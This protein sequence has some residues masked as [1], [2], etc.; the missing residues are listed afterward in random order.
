MVNEVPQT[1]ELSQT[2]RAIVTA[3]GLGVA[4]SRV[5]LT[6]TLSLAASTVSIRVQELLDWGLLEEI[7]SGAS[8]GGRRPSL[9]QVPGG[10]GHFVAIDSGAQHVRIGIADFQGELKHTQE[11]ACKLSLGPDAVLEQIAD[12]IEKLQAKFVP[13][14]PLRGVCLGLPGP[15]DIIHGWADSGT[16]LPG[17]SRFPVAQ[18]LSER[19]R[20]RSI[21]ENDANL[22]ALGEHLV[23]AGLSTSITV[24]AGSAIGSGLV[25]DGSLFRG[26]SGM[27]GDIAHARLPSAPDLPC[28]CGNTGCLETVASGVALLE[29]YREVGGKA[30][31]LRDLVAAANNG[32]PLATTLVREAGN[33]LGEMLCIVV[34]FANPEALFV[35]GLLSTVEPFVAAIRAALYGGCHSMVTRNL[36][37]AKTTRGADAGLYGALHLIR[38]KALTE[39]GAS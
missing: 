11:V 6:R 19:L 34:G 13:N 5:D 7:G 15:I 30:Q 9:L 24:K 14:S 12:N 32:D 4:T 17:W 37:I 2:H 39:G 38:G 35:G 31:S 26:A 29:Q 21:V 27:A 28:A 8:R 1:D 3:V 18:W 25:I 20:V 22:M 33:R 23:H 36:L 10:A 16:R